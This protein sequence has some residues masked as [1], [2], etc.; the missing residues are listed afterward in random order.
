MLL[1]AG[2]CHEVGLVEVRRE[3]EDVTDVSM[4]LSCLLL[5][6]VCS[7]IPNK[8]FLLGDETRIRLLFNTLQLSCA[9]EVAW[10]GFR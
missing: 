10:R 6:L 1:G 5:S 3:V 8:R 2:T 4:R 9:L 7:Q